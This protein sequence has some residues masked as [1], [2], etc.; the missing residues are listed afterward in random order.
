MIGQ[1]GNI[2]IDQFKNLPFVDKYAG[3]VKSITYNE[4]NGTAGT[5][6]KIFPAACTLTATECENYSRYLDLCPDSSKK[7]VMYL[8]DTGLRLTKREGNYLYFSVQ[9]NLVVWLNMP[10]L[11]YTGCSYS[12]IAIIDIIKSIPQRPFNSGNYHQVSINFATQ[13][14]KSLNPF[15]KYSY[16]ETVN[17]FLMYPYDYF[18]LALNI[19]FKMDLRC[20][21]ITPIDSEIDC[22]IK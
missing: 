1:I 4:K 11:G 18:V 9:L 3:V 2:V 13:Q 15:S 21:E 19:D 6:K 20:L 12:A 5:I 16:D 14:P 10:K 17:Q 8:E 7:S 22:L